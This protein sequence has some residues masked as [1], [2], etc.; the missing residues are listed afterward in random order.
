MCL[1]E[2]ARTYAFEVITELR[3]YGFRCEMD[4][5]GRSF[6][7]QF[8]AVDRAKSKT[9]VLIGSTEKD[10]NQVTIKNLSKREQETISRDDLISYMDS[11]MEE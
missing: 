9:A 4:M 8:K 3:A 6:K 5:M 2:D 1:D 11:L 7:G 10:A